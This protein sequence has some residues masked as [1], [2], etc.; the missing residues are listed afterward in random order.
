MTDKQLIYYI[1]GKLEGIELKL[2]DVCNTTKHNAK[3]I[4]DHDKVIAR[5]FGWISG[6]AIVIGI[7]VNFSVDIIKKKFL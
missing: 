4:A 1:K 5:A 3:K 6:I 2:N 7:V